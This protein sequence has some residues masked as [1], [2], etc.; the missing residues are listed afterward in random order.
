MIRW[1]SRLQSVSWVILPGSISLDQSPGLV[2]SV[3]LFNQSLCAPATSSKSIGYNQVIRSEI[4][5]STFALFNPDSFLSRT[6]EHPSFTPKDIL[7]FGWCSFTF[8]LSRQIRRRGLSSLRR[9]LSMPSIW[10]S[11]TASISKPLSLVTKLQW[12]LKPLYS[13]RR[14]FGVLKD[15][16][17]SS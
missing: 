9:S 15:R 4:E 5:P 11:R 8:V 7:H 12:I 16:L 10:R 17:G 3:S 1:A 13:F 14:S 2:S 6:P